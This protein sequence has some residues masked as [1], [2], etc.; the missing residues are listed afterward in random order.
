MRLSFICLF[1]A[2]CSG[3][4]PHWQRQFTDDKIA[5]AEFP[6]VPMAMDGRGSKLCYNV[7]GK[8]IGLCL[9]SSPLPDGE[10]SVVIKND[11][12]RNNPGYRLTET[13]DALRNATVQTAAAYLGDKVYRAVAA[14]SDGQDDRS[15]TDRFVRS[16]KVSTERR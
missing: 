2:G 16:F 4:S 9:S 6:G 14:W 7:P 8:D 12:A 1:L 3:G 13:R 11:N 5:S 10:R 15:L